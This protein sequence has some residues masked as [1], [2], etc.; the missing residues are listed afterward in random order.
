MYAIKVFKRPFKSAYL[1]R[2]TYRE[3]KIL[4][5]LGEMPNNEFTPKIKD[6][7]LPKQIY[8]YANLDFWQ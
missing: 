8:S 6:I 7:I 2:Q 3:I 4:R 1:A 5:K